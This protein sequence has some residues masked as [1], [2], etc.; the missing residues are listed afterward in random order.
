MKTL[1]LEC[2]MGAAGDMLMAALYEL[3]D[4]QPAFLQKMQELGLHGVQ[5]T[6][7]PAKT[8]GIAGTHMRVTVHG[9]EE[10]EPD[11]HEHDH[12][13]D[14]HHDDHEHEHHHHHHDEH[15][16]E[17]HHHHD[18]HD[19]HHHHDDHEHDHHH[20]HE[21][22]HGHHHHHATPG[23][24]AAVIDGLNLPEAVKQH[25]RAVYD[26]IAQA[27]AKAHGC[28]VGDV[29]YHEVGALD[30]VA[31][32][33]GV[34]YAMY[35]LGVDRVVVSP[36]HVGSG[37]VRC[38]HGVMPVPAPATAN[39]LAGVP[40][41]SGS[42]QG[43]LCTPTGAALLTHFA[44]AFEKMPVMRT[45]KVGIGI[46]TKQFEE[47]ANCVRAFLGETEAQTNGT[48][49]ELVCNLDDLSAEAL[50]LACEQLLAAGALDVYTVPG[51]MK[52]GRAGQVLTVL[53]EDKDTARMAERVLALTTTNGLR[54]RRCEKY[55]LQPSARE[56][57]TA[58][59]QVRVKVA[60]G[61]GITHVKPEFEDVAAIARK[62]GLS[63]DTVAQ[64]VRQALN[65]EENA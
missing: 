31:D 28:P 27:E 45:Q 48:I 11:A 50:A 58:W 55:F 15:D 6:A 18:D 40:V 10:H 35:L 14:H 2:N 52:K 54:V 26:A 30:A 1:Y 21:H 62:T 24:I 65:K 38:A 29:H 51:T 39:L 37:T 16:H 59:G 33:T 20:A 3:L 46:G 4:D 22:A 23:H 61:F 56:V 43:E 25:A 42:V 44:D 34:C 36:V 63:Y 5:V 60:E 13:H 41:Y 53:C 19:H 7:E 47:Q 8:C 17:H 12:H 9:E 64:A 32:V 57:S 49:T